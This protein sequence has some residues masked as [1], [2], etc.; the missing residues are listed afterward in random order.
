MEKMKIEY[1]PITELVEYEN[2]AKI[3]TDEQIEQIKESFNKFMRKIPKNGFVVVNADD[4]N[5]MSS[6][7]DVECE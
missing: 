4:P 6:T 2:N 3:H 5:V 7:H 1:I